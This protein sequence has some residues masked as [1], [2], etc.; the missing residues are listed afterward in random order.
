M[1]TAQRTLPMGTQIHTSVIGYYDFW[2]T[3]EVGVVLLESL[4]VTPATGKFS[5][6]KG[7]IP[8]VVKPSVAQKY[9]SP[10]NVIWAK[11]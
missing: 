5:K 11:E 6:V 4:T 7:L 2:Y 8:Y 1:P 3:S 9:G 10:I